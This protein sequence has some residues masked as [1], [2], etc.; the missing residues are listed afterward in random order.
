MN[1]AKKWH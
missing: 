1:A